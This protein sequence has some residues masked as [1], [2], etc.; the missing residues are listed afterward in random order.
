MSCVST[1]SVC[2]L[3]QSAFFPSFQPLF[4]SIKI[5]FISNTTPCSLTYTYLGPTDDTEFLTCTSIFITYLHSADSKILHN[6]TN[7]A[8]ISWLRIPDD[9]SFVG[10]AV[11]AW[12]IFILLLIAIFRSFYF[13]HFSFPSS[14]ISSYSKSLPVSAV[15]LSFLFFYPVCFIS[16][17]TLLHFLFLFSFPFSFSHFC[18]FQENW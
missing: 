8:N 3:S 2:H 10:T 18:F 5:T 4:V 16:P 6:M 1:N 12:I 11:R 17:I 7:F 9:S 13:L 15:L 14:F